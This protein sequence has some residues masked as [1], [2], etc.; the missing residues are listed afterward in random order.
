MGR[1][2]HGG[3]MTCAA[4]ALYFDL[5]M[6]GLPS[7]L[8]ILIALGM[9]LLGLT[10]LVMAVGILRPP[11]MNDGK[12]MARL[13]RLSP[14]DL[15]LRFSDESFVVRDEKS[16]RTL[17]IAGWWI[18]APAP[19][20]QCA[21]LLHGYADAKVGAIAWAPLLH[22]VGLNV[23]AIDLRAHGESGGSD[24]T[25]GYYERDDVNQ[26]ID[27]LLA[28]R[29][30]ETRRMVLFGMSLGAAV[31]AATAAQRHDIAAVVMDSPF[32]DYGRIVSANAQV[33]G[34]PGGLILQGALKLAEWLS[35]AN[36]AK[37][38]TVD[39]IAKI[40]CPL[41]MIFGGDDELL[42][43]TDVAALEKSIQR[44]PPDAALVSV[45]IIENARHLTAIHE[46]EAE[47]ESKLA[48]FLEHALMAPTNK[49]NPKRGFGF[50]C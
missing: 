15:G 25:G 3:G 39:A 30:G 13:R 23:L 1:P 14:G 41:M 24:S 4:A 17:R 31:A 36:F 34:L 32:V 21:I 2:L 16:G 50:D 8:C 22:G 10:M 45:V 47:Y 26:V 44:R 49:K 11:R 19:S 12:A 43:K 48:A 6:S 18:F 28:R 27:Q 29:P 35:G 42:D 9:L 40:R 7:L 20:D 46:N 5:P 37:V 38:S 33:I